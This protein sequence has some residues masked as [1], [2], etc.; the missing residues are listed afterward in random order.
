MK[1]VRTIC[2]AAPSVGFVA[3]TARAMENH[4]RERGMSLRRQLFLAV[5]ATVL[6][7]AVVTVL[8][9]G[10]LTRRASD[11]QVL[12][13]VS[14]QAALIASRERVALLPLGHLDSL[15]SFLARQDESVRVESLRS[16][17]PY[18]DADALA[19]L[20]R[21]G[22]FAGTAHGDG[23]DW[24]LAARPVA[25]KALV[26][27]RPRV[28]GAA[29]WR[30]YVDALLIGAGVGAALAAA[31]SLLLA[32]RIAQPL[33]RVAAASRSLAAD[34][35]P[36]T[37]PAA[38]PAELRS[39]ARSFND[40]AEQLA[41]ARDAERAFLLS[42]S[43]ELKT[44]LTAVIGYAEALADGTVEP[45]VAARTIAGEAERLERLVRDVLDLARMNRHAFSVRRERVDLVETAHEC[46]RRH[47]DLGVALEVRGPSAAA[48]LGD[49]DRVLQ[50]LSN[51]VENAI[52]IAPPGG[53][54]LIEVAPGLLAVEDAGPGIAPDELPHAF[55][56][57]YLHA[58]YAGS[59]AVGTGLGLAIVRELAEA[60]G[61][62]VA[63]E[64]R[65][66]RTRFSLRL[67]AAGPSERV[68]D[69]AEPRP[70]TTA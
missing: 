46:V 40:M 24:Y 8:V 4:R 29:A 39:L 21:R 2:I 64:S 28:V 68:T 53:R 26:L 65:P 5:T 17:S 1:S 9:G 58:K 61:G 27:L 66:G 43:H 10:L 23:R 3:W 62:S 33:R 34:A 35:D 54:V 31:V 6:L 20:R 18:L 56:R 59:R 48:A 12:E 52:R 63:V 51:L 30:P 15:R 16:P 14:Q 45:E 36:G 69:P 38:G 13:D 25:G 19:M 49:A 67:P 44:P 11:R 32:R 55:D 22:S 50:A 42:V 70:M 57:F 7:A 41:H 47:H 60:M 37:V